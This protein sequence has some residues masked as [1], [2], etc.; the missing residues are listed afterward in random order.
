MFKSPVAALASA[1]MLLIF[2]PELCLTARS[3]AAPSTV[4]KLNLNAAVV[5]DPEFCA[6]K[7]K[8]NHETF[9]VGKDA[10]EVLKPTLEEGFS[11]VTSVATDKD[12]V[13]AQAILMPRFVDV[14]ATKTMG[15]FS[16]RE[17]TVLLEWT[18]KNKSGR[19]G[20]IET[21]Q[22]SGKNHMGNAFSY[23]TD[24]KQIINY[25]VRD[26][27]HKSVIAMDASPEMRK[28]E[29]RTASAP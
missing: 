9:E 29:Q 20:W 18:V 15:A 21:V 16:T 7:I 14:S 19:T 23:K 24:L 8:K 3:Q 25:A 17:L 26:L 1:L 27:A 2:L 12:A 5:V 22:G 11:R 10:C 4:Q 6:T 28:L 13:D